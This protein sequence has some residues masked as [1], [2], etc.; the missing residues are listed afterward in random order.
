MK[1]KVG[2]LHWFRNNLDVASSVVL[3]CIP[4][5]VV[6]HSIIEGKMNEIRIFLHFSQRKNIH[7][8]NNLEG[9]GGEV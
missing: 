5:D 2:H 4:W 7:A 9:N 1:V 8:S 6:S 3:Q